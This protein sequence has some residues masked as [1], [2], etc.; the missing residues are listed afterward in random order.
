[1]I[2]GWISILRS[3]F[4]DCLYQRLPPTYKKI[5][6]Q[7]TLSLIA[8]RPCPSS[9]VVRDHHTLDSTPSKSRGGPDVA[10]PTKIDDSS[11][12]IPQQR[13]DTVDDLSVPASHDDDD[14][15]GDDD[16]DDDD[17]DNEGS[18]DS[19]ESSNTTQVNVSSMDNRTPI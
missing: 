8:N 11:A 5:Q 7:Q 2:K 19:V 16:D 9:N 14:K 3:E 1:M 18:A 12:L 6:R 4:V 13:S 15:D 10:V 17:N